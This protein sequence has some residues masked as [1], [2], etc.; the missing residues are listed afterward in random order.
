MYIIVY[1]RRRAGCTGRLFSV[2]H[3]RQPLCPPSAV[4]A[5]TSSRH[6]HQLCPLLKPRAAPGGSH[7]AR[8]EGLCVLGGGGG[9]TA[10]SAIAVPQARTLYCSVGK[11]DAG[12]KEKM[13]FCLKELPDT[14]A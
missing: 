9:S 11:K 13:I 10:I 7:G 1:V 5:G 3:G 14:A 8:A 2:G 4:G 6:L 12:R